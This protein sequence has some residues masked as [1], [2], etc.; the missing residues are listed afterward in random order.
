MPQLLDENGNPLLDEAGNPLADKAAPPEPSPTTS[1]GRRITGSRLSDVASGLYEGASHA[2]RGG[3]D[4]M[5]EVGNEYKEHPV[6]NTMMMGMPGTATVLARNAVKGGK[7]L[8]ENAEKRAQAALTQLDLLKN[9]PGGPPSFGEFLSAPETRESMRQVA[10]TVVP[11]IE[12]EELNPGSGGAEVPTG[13]ALGNETVNLAIAAGPDIAKAILP[14]APVRSLTRQ[15]RR[16]AGIDDAAEALKSLEGEHPLG[17]ATAA[18]R[19]AEVDAAT[20]QAYKARRAHENRLYRPLDNIPA[21]IRELAGEDF[22][23]LQDAGVTIP[24][25]IEKRLAAARRAAAKLP[26]VAEG[27][28]ATSPEH[29]AALASLED[30]PFSALKEMRS[31]IGH[32]LAGLRASGSPA[33]GRAE[34]W[35]KALTGAMEDAAEAAG[36]SD[37]YTAANNF[38][39]YE[40][41]QNHG[42]IR[43]DAGARSVRSAGREIA[44]RAPAYNEAGE[45]IV[46]GD[47]EGMHKILPNGNAGAVEAAHR[48]LVPRGSWAADALTTTGQRA[49]DNLVEQKVTKALTP[50]GAAE[51]DLTKAA[52]RINDMGETWDK[53]KELASPEQRQ[54]MQ[55]LETVANAYA[56]IGQGSAAADVTLG[57]IA[58][59]GLGML[60]GHHGGG[61][62]GAAAGPAMRL[63]RLTPKVLRWALEH[64]A[65]TEVLL[66]DLAGA[67]SG[68]AAVSAGRNVSNILRMYDMAQEAPPDAKPLRLWRGL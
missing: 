49:F 11:E 61:I 12:T 31:D 56:K 42:M 9:R 54:R 27:E 67:S 62:L 23:A 6:I 37:E 18:E 26:E 1:T 50:R 35:Y 22:K 45:K 53:M 36:K 59:E 34:Q 25:E 68:Q 65:R 19:G 55:A 60:A 10:H 28:L 48:T 33:A 3:L 14:T 17:N 20:E 38:H 40:V 47:L 41:M 29:E 64:P 7:A 5:G 44:N 57:A 15:I 46:G 24:K 8:A 2:V 13:R 63:S 21:D 30:V 32:K 16:M 43:R 39:R 58:G 52:K 51:I 4:F 66:Q